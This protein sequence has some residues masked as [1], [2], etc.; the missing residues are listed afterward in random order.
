MIIID[1]LLVYCQLIP[2]TTNS[3]LQGIYWN[4][5]PYCFIEFT[6]HISLKSPLISSLIQPEVHLQSPLQFLTFCF[7]A[8]IFE[9][10]PSEAFVPILDGIALIFFRV[11]CVNLWILSHTTWWNVSRQL[12]V[13]SCLLGLKSNIHSILCIISCLYFFHFQLYA[14]SPASFSPWND[15]Q[16]ALIFLSSAHLSNFPYRLFQKLSVECSPAVMTS[17][18]NKLILV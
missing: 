10:L 7:S 16:L 11:A 2:F 5:F 12:C 9:V 13:F 8:G 1:I 14:F 6:S 3:S 15:I 4:H 18:S 17:V